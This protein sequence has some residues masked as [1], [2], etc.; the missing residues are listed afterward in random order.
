MKPL[1]NQ[2]YTVR[3]AGTMLGVRS[4]RGA[5]YVV[6]FPSRKHAELVRGH[7]TEATTLELRNHCPYDASAVINE[8]LQERNR[9]IRVNAVYVDETAQ[10]FVAKRTNINPPPPGV[11]HE[12]T[13]AEFISM[14]FVNN[15]GIVFGIDLVHEDVNGLVFDAYVVDPADEIRLFKP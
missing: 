15:V 9:P 1:N 5:S 4:P 14:P 3:A 6:A 8:G 10:L 12:G 2:M 7:V 11:L 13:L